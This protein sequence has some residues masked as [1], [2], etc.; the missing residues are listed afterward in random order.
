MKMGLVSE[1]R[2][3]H[4]QQATQI[5]KRGLIFKFAKERLKSAKSVQ[6]I[7]KSFVT[8]TR[9]PTSLILGYFINFS[10]PKSIVT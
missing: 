9:H 2:Y 1:I 10:L 7:A 3:N 5:E 4:C 8:G 6:R